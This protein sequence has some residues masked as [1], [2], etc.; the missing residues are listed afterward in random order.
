VGLNDFIE[1][2]IDLSAVFDELIT[3]SESEPSEFWQKK[4]EIFKSCGEHVKIVKEMYEKELLYPIDCLILLESYDTFTD[5]IN[6][7]PS[8]RYPYHFAKVTSRDSRRIF[9]KYIKNNNIQYKRA[10]ND[11]KPLSTKNLY[12]DLLGN[13]RDFSLDSKILKQ[14]IDTMFKILEKKMEEREKLLYQ[15]YD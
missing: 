15:F 6:N 2:H 4:P 14:G 5:I 9:I 3:I 13:I 8:I 10:T 12:Y 7:F 1:E 11:D